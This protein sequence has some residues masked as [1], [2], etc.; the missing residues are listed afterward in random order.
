MI[1]NGYFENDPSDS[2]GIQMIP[3]IAGRVDD[4][5]ENDIS[6]AEGIQLRASAMPDPHY[7]PENKVRINV[8][9][10]YDLEFIGTLPE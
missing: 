1:G 10:G 7:P 4:I 6:D 2:A 9:Y 5:F 8:H 3:G